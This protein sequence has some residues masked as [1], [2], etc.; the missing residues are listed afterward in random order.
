[1][2]RKE[3]GAGEIDRK[4]FN[5]GIVAGERFDVYGYG[6]KGTYVTRGI[7]KVAGIELSSGE[8]RTK[9]AQQRANKISE[10]DFPN[11]QGVLF[12]R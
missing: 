10:R 11:K 8:I 4:P 7:T 5:W 1:M 2:A 9:K 6:R 12:E 3:L